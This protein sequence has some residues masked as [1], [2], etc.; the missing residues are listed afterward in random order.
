MPWSPP[1]GLSGEVDF[2]EMCP[3]NSVAS[4]YAGCIGSVAG[5]CKQGQWASAA[6]LHGPKHVRFDVEG[7]NVRTQ[8]CNLDRTGWSETSHYTNFLARAQS[9]WDVF[10]S[11]VWNG[12]GGDGGW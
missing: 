4:N 10:V 12:H 3:V 6:G 8:V 11:D 2:V 1:A 9:T 5:R 7:E